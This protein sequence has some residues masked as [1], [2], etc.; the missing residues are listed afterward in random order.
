MT[1][2]VVGTSP[3]QTPIWIGADNGLF[4]KH[5]SPVQLFTTTAPVAMAALLKGDVQIAID[6]GA[7]IG[8]DPPGTRLAFIAAQQ[9]AFNQF[10]VYTKPSIKTLQELKGKT[11]GAA[12]PGSAATVAFEKIL[13]S[14]GL[15]YKSDVK[16]I[17]LGT[18]AAQ[19]TALSQGQIDGGINAW[20]Y[21]LLARQAGFNK[22]ADAKEMKIAG[23]SNTLGAQ[24]Q[25]LKA[26]AKLAEGF[27]KGF[28][29]GTYLANTDRAKFGAALSKHTEVKE[30]AQLEEAWER[31][32]G[33][34][35]WPPYISKEAVQEAIEDEP[36]EAVRSHKPEDYIENGPLDAIVASG[37]TKQ[38][39][40]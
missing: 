16:W 1:V 8:F 7:M 13:K 3:S 11:V 30:E 34:Y 15:D 23:A 5:G 17:Y 4:E 36:N 22:L 19:W 24:R 26:N 21:S 2:A 12:S 39:E 14:A 25:W 18:P 31:F 35:P 29:E 40:K 33:T 27:L 32:R 9:N 38:F 6:G 10:A 37:F 20:P 28:T